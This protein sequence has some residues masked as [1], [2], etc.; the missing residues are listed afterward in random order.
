VTQTGS[1]VI[2]VPP[3]AGTRNRAYAIAR[4]IPEGVDTVTVDCVDLLACTGSF[5]DEL[6]RQVFRY[7]KAGEMRVIR[8]SD[9]DFRRFLDRQAASHRV[10]DRVVIE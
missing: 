1:N 4:N 6:L 2:T 7:R 10:S 5:V 3:L 8:L 9:D